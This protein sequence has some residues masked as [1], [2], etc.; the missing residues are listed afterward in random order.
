MAEIIK[1]ITI[2]LR[3]EKRR[4]VDAALTVLAYA[5]A[6]ASCVSLPFAGRIRDIGCR[7]IARYGIKATAA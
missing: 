5:Y 3:V 4:G 1:P 7:L 6:L 2:I